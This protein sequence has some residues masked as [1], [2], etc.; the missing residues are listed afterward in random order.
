M[1]LNNSPTK[2]VFPAPTAKVPARSEY[3]Q[4][5]DRGAKN[6]R[7]FFSGVSLFAREIFSTPFQII[8]TAENIFG[9]ATGIDYNLGNRGRI[10]FQKKFNSVVGL[11]DS[12]VSERGDFDEIG[13]NFQRGVED[14]RGGNYF[15]AAKGFGLS[16]FYTAVSAL[17]LVGAGALVSGTARGVGGVAKSAVALKGLKVAGKV[18]DIPDL[19][20]TALTAKQLERVRDITKAPPVQRYTN[21]ANTEIINI[22]GK[23]DDI[24]TISQRL[25]EASDIAVKTQVSDEVVSLTRQL[26]KQVQ[27][28]KGTYVEIP[29]TINAVEIKR[30]D[31]PAVRVADVSPIEKSAV[32]S[33]NAFAKAFNTVSNSRIARTIEPYNRKGYTDFFTDYANKFVEKAKPLVENPQALTQKALREIRVEL[34]ILRDS[35]K[36]DLKNLAVKSNIESG[37]A[38]GLSEANTKKLV[39]QLQKAADREINTTIN[40]AFKVIGR[41]RKIAQLDAETIAG[42]YASKI[43]KLKNRGIDIKDDIKPLIGNAVQKA[44]KFKDP[45]K[46]LETL[47][48]TIYN[49][50]VKQ[51]SRSLKPFLKEGILKSNA[52]SKIEKTNLIK[53]VDEEIGKFAK[54]ESTIEQLQ[55]QMD[56]FLTKDGASILNDGFAR[57]EDLKKNAQAFAVGIKNPE[58]GKLEGGVYDPNSSLYRA[59]YN[60]KH[61]TKAKQRLSSASKDYR[62]IVDEVGEEAAQNTPQHVELNNAAIEYHKTEVSANFD[63]KSRESQTVGQRF[64]RITVG[65]FATAAKKI[66]QEGRVADAFFN[67]TQAEALQPTAIRDMFKLP[68]GTVDPLIEKTL[69]VNLEAAS[70]GTQQ[71]KKLNQESIQLIDGE[72]RAYLTK[73]NKEAGKGRVASAADLFSKGTL[74]HHA[75]YSAGLLME[76]LTASKLN[77]EGLAAKGAKLN[78]ATKQAEEIAEALSISLKEHGVDTVVTGEQVANFARKIDFTDEAKRLATK[79]EAMRSFRKEVLGMDEG[80]IDIFDKRMYPYLDEIKDFYNTKVKDGYTIMYGDAAPTEYD[81]YMPLYAK[82]GTLVDDTADTPFLDLKNLFSPE[83]ET[84]QAGVQAKIR[85]LNERNDTIS[86]KAYSL[87]L[88]SV[89]GNSTEKLYRFGH[90]A[91]TMFEAAEILKTLPQMNQDIKNAIVSNLSKM[92]SQ[93]YYHDGVLGA[94]A[95]FTA[96]INVSRFLATPQFAGGTY[97]ARGVEALNGLTKG[98][99]RWQVAGK[100][101]SKSNP[102]IREWIKS[103]VIPERLD[104]FDAARVDAQMLR[105]QAGSQYGEGI[106]GNVFSKDS[107]K[108]I[109]EGIN[110][111][112]GNKAL[113]LVTRPEQKAYE[114]VAVGVLFEEYAKKFKKANP[115]VA[116]NAIPTPT[117][118]QLIEISDSAAISKVKDTLDEIYGAVTLERRSVGSVEA[119]G[120]TALLTTLTGHLTRHKRRLSTAHLRDRVRKGVGLDL[121][122]E[123][124]LSYEQAPTFW[125]AITDFAES[126]ATYQAGRIVTRDAIAVATGQEDQST[127]EDFNQSIRG[128]MLESLF[129]IGWAGQQV[130]QPL[131]DSVSGYG[132]G[133]FES[134]TDAGAVFQQDTVLD[135]GK[136]ALTQFT[137]PGNLLFNKNSALA[138]VLESFERFSSMD[139]SDKHFRDTVRGNFRSNPSIEKGIQESLRFYRHGDASTLPWGTVTNSSYAEEAAA[140]E[141]IFNTATDFPSTSIFEKLLGNK[142]R[143]GE[144]RDDTR[145][146]TIKRSRD[147]V[148]SAGEAAR[149]M[150]SLYTLLTMSNSD[151]RALY[152][153][154]REVARETGKGNYTTKLR[155]W[156]K[157]RNKRT[158]EI[159]VRAVS[160]YVQQVE[161]AIERKSTGDRR[162]DNSF[163]GDWQRYRG[164]I[165][166]IVG[167]L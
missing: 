6:K 13:Y 91:P 30:I 128:N 29:K 135:A 37:V 100:Q 122:D 23:A 33:Y 139:Y 19:A 153:L 73:A 5:L 81:F 106:R 76:N 22:G 48:E 152:D 157:F 8:N 68:D 21:P 156:S 154:G 56:D 166:G 10:A 25:L 18:A 55:N 141:Q 51:V 92:V 118:E 120:L 83:T 16:A 41:R 64:G 89:Y 71:A 4:F 155:S 3:Q 72:L 123:L 44:E 159:N 78:E 140:K 161:R 112:T 98:G 130:S 149:N 84:T 31:I 59:G 95:K 1:P 79:K 163:F 144:T 107:L 52:V 160:S 46:V 87:N 121:A 12:T 109:M 15:G 111:R 126:E 65:R 43:E 26:A 61:A 164:K 137:F 148:K 45:R 101:Y 36:V 119:D 129:S 2:S 88:P 167:G 39:Q 117:V 27:L 113:S 105:G 38:S 138:P 145:L 7:T 80:V 77:I 58:T 151:Y 32:I 70:F 146:S 40:N 97:L 75:R 42:D 147:T 53:S 50:Y 108:T 63:F 103:E 28:S 34:D 82:E 127:L 102:E 9:L 143:F 110:T 133:I 90:A 162:Q 158:G 115:D 49:N 57:R 104:G 54:G 85:Q 67:T 124:E 86:G 150:R 134:L 132:F 99:Q 14:A 60:K 74:S 125:N 35:L 93:K 66:T 24:E 11:P 131:F 17:D 136:E 62:K 114:D 142:D 20:K 96:G 47:Q 69:G 116:Y 165:G 94:M